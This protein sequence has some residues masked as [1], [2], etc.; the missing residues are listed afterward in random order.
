MLALGHTPR[1]STNPI[2]TM[3]YSARL[4]QSRAPGTV[5]SSRR[6]RASPDR[7]GEAA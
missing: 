6:P 3:E 7:G 1:I 4:F 2:G 5:L